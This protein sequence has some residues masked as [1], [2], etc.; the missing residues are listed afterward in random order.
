MIILRKS[1]YASHIMLPSKTK[2]LKTAP[3]NLITSQYF[4]ILLTVFDIILTSVIIFIL[5]NEMR[6]YLEDWHYSV[7]QY[8]TNDLYMLLQNHP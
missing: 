3:V 5:Y 8:F 4:K 2:F 6:E 1:I 7:N